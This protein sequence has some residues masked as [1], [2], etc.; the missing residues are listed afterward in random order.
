MLNV[1][2]PVLRSIKLCN[3]D[4]CSKD[5]GEYPGGCTP[6]RCVFIRPVA[7][8]T[9]FFGLGPASKA[10]LDRTRPAGELAQKSMQRPFLSQSP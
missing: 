6:K 1:Q 3:R 10:T 5:Y 7:W 9:Y 2:S 8:I 4:I